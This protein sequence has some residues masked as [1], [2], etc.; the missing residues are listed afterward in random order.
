MGVA[1]AHSPGFWVK[2]EHTGV[3]EGLAGVPEVRWEQ[4]AET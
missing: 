2:T 4:G 1:T 3:W